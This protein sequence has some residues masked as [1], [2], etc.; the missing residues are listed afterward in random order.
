MI[1]LMH[2]I[3]QMSGDTYVNVWDCKATLVISGVSEDEL[4][5]SD[6]QREAL[7]KLKDYIIYTVNGGAIN[8]S[9]I[10][11]LDMT[12][13]EILEEILK[14]NTEVIEKIDVPS[15]DDIYSTARELIESMQEGDYATVYNSGLAC[16]E[17]CQGYHTIEY[18]VKHNGRYIL[19]D[20]GQAHHAI[21]LGCK[22]FKILKEL[23][24]EE[25]VERLAEYIK[26]VAEKSN[27]TKLEVKN[28]MLDSELDNAKMLYCEK[29]K[30]FYFDDV[31][32]PD[33]LYEQN[34]FS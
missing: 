30:R 17:G 9:G 26:Q 21:C 4:N 33:C 5:L 7:E 14:G 8:I 18:I 25:A 23:T 12:S 11:Y 22:E 3:N 34:S 1:D 31:G 15:E 27:Y 20:N 24:K 13:L 19:T 10:Y 32:C 6:K 16:Y 28:Y 2:L 29:H